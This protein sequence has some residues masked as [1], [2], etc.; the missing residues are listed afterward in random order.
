MRQLSLVPLLVLVAAAGAC[1]LINAPDEVQPSGGAGGSTGG[2]CQTDDDCRTSDIPCTRYACALG[3]VCQLVTLADGAKCDDGRFCTVEDACDDGKC[4]GAAR[5]CPDQ[6]A[7]N[8]GSCDEAA[9]A[10]AIVVAAAGT[11]CDDGDPCTEDG[12]CTNGVC[13]KGPD[14]CAKL[15]TDCTDATCEQGMGCVVHD[16]LDGT[17]C[18]MS[19]CSNGTCA[20][21]HCDITAINEGASCNDGLFCTVDDTC[22]LGFCVGAPN[23]CP[24]GDQC[25]KGTCDEAADA[26]LMEPIADNSPCDDGDACTANEFCSNDVCIGGLPPKTL[27]N[28]SFIDNSQ[29]WQLDQEWQIGLAEPSSGQEVGNGDPGFDVTGEG[30]VA[31]VVLGGNAFVAAEDPTHPARYLTSP[32]LDTLQAGA[33]YLTFYRWLNSDYA[34]YMRNTIEASTDG[35]TWSVVWETGEVPVRDEEWTFQ[36]VDITAFKGKTTRVRFGFSIDSNFVYRVSSWNL[37]LIKVQ[38]APCPF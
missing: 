12:A 22:T 24:T 6:D 28:E 17:G 32:V 35:E 36:A 16:K 31:G 30:R 23:P 27:F 29:G 3:G 11:S 18:G 2:K 26:C 37:D 10:C 38:N 25:I 34:P 19:F 9:D 13:G 8:V 7:C 5:A 14:A 21:G 15:S 4:A 33:I 1:S 20:A